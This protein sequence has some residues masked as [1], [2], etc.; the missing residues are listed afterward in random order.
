MAGSTGSIGLIGVS[1]QAAALED[2]ALTDS[3][4]ELRT[5][6]TTLRLSLEESQRRLIS[7]YPESEVS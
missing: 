5:R 7:Q 2:V 6:M 3:E 1:R 4:A